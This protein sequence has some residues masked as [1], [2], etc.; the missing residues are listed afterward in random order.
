MQAIRFAGHD[1][2]AVLFSGLKLRQDVFIVEQQSIYYDLDG[3]D[4]RNHALFSWSS[5]Q[6]WAEL[7]GYARIVSY[8]QASILKLSAVV[9]FHMARK[10]RLT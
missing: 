6:D 9:F 8:L 1:C 2:S 3:L 4:H 10:H 5:Q 7:I